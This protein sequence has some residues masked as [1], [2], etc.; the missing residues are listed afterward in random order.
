MRTNK[1]RIALLLGMMLLGLTLAGC[2]ST[3][4]D[5]GLSKVMDK[6]VLVMG[7]DDAF[8]PMGFRDE[9]QN[10]VGFDVDVA[11]EVASRMGVELQLQPI[12]WSSKEQELSAGNVDC[13]WNGFTKTPQRE[14]QMCLSTAYMK[15]TQVVVLPADSTVQSI[16]DLAGKTVVVQSGSSAELAID[17]LEGF[18]ESLK[19]LVAVSDNVT[20]MMDLGT[21]SSDAV[22]MDEVVAR[23]YMS[24]NEGQY[25]LLEESLADEEYVIGF[26]KQN[27][28]LKDAVEE[29][30]Y[31]MAEDGTLAEISEK[32]FGEDLTT[33]GK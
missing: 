28:S 27:Q 8:P 19:E 20:A 9:D 11:T 4:E 22:V 6:G 1:R 16:D 14:E 29:Q 15:N 18:E 3:G 33:L 26:A 7:L 21:G 12:D 23:Y 2:A 25:R 13:L 5:V 32:W 30:L 24:K 10:I 31:A 17:E